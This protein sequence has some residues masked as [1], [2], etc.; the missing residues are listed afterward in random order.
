MKLMSCILMGVGSII[1]A[2]VFASTPIAIK[3]VGGNGIVIGF[4]CAALFVFLRS[5]P[6]MLLVSALPAKWWFLH[7]SDPYGTSGHG[8]L[9]RFQ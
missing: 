1:G 4:I 2:S 3:I 5:I 6:E 7:V 9:G 8:N